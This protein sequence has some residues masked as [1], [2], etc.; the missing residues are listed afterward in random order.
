M[1]RSVVGVLIHIG[2]CY[3]KIRAEESISRLKPIHT[4]SGTKSD[5]NEA[6]LNLDI[7]PVWKCSNIGFCHGNIDLPQAT[8]F[9]HERNHNIPPPSRRLLAC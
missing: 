1:R 9:F 8:T 7:E 6:C 2:L 5:G 4:M 3:D